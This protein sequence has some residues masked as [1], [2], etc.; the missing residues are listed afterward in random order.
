MQIMEGDLVANLPPAQGPD[1]PRPDRRQS[2]PQRAR[3]RRDQLSLRVRDARPGGLRRLGRLRVQAEGPDLARASRWFAPYRGSRL[4]DTALGRRRGHEGRIHRA[5]ASWAGP[6]PGTREG[7]HELFL[8]DLNPR[9]AGAARQGRHVACELGPGGGASRPRSSSPWCPDT[10]HVEAALFGAG[11]RRR[12]P[13]ARQDRGRHELD[14]ADRDQG[15]RQ[16]DQRA[17]LRL[18]RRA[19]LGRRGRGQ[20]GLAH[21][22]GRRA[23]GRLREGEAAVRAHGQ[24]HHAGRRQRRRPDRQGRQP[25]HRGADHRGGGRGAAVRLQGRRRPGARCARR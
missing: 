8:F 3:H 16:A 15:V 22:H 17:G 10:P 5:R 12:G 7:G 20:G 23:R 24:E 2:R 13:L 19:G 25:D 9:A 1:R 6:W 4:S 18:S 11:R 21:D 14:L